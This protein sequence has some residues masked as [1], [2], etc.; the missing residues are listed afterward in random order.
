MKIRIAILLIAL[1]IMG[2]AMTVSGISNLIKLNGNVPDFNYESMQNIKKGDFV[3]GYI[4]NI[5]GCYANTTTTESTFGIETD[6]YVSD[7]Y[8]LMP[9][10]NDTDLA[11]D[12]YITVVGTKKEDRN[13][14]YAINDATWEYYEGNVD[15]EFPEMGIVAKVSKLGDEYEQFL[16]EAMLD[17][18][19]Y[20]TAAEARSHIIPY[21][22]TIYN[23]SAPYTSL[24]IGLL[25]VAVFIVVGIIVFTKFKKEREQQTFIPAAEP[26]MGNFTAENTSSANS[27]AE[28]YT[29]PQPVPIPDIPQPTDAD[30]FFARTP[31]PVAPA[32]KEVPKEEPVAPAAS[33]SPAEPVLGD[34]DALDTTGLL[35]DADYE[36]D[37]NTDD[38]EFIE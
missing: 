37:E 25:I 7:E 21:K 6:S 16:V 19:Y 18:E 33:I 11:A 3:Q 9:L 14:L 15:V 24:G 5:D 4:W 8:F 13:L 12:M 10:V 31:K 27:F 32:E 36:I 28:S 17:A 29:P 26:S 22:L 35:N 38:S 20:T 30:E 1:F 34:M 2:I 23:P